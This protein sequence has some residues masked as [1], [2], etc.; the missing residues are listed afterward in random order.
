MKCERVRCDQGAYCCRG[1]G[2]TV[3]CDCGGRSAKDVPPLPCHILFSI[4]RALVGAEGHLPRGTRFDSAGGG[5]PN[6]GVA[7]GSSLRQVFLNNGNDENAPVA[8]DFL[9]EPLELNLG[10][11]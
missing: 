5:C 8:F 1:G 10:S 6:Q 11:P 2:D 3:A 7:L 9:D 4:K